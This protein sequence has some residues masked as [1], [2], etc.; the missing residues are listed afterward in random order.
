MP[1]ALVTKEEIGTIISMGEEEGVV[2]ED[3]ATM[4]RKVVK[5]GERQVREVMTPRT[6]VAWIEKEATLADFFETYAEAP[7]LRYPVYEGTFD[8]VIGFISVRD[9]VLA[10]A[11]GIL[12]RKSPLEE[13]YRP[14]YSV[15]GN[16]LVGELFAEMRS[17]GYLMAVVIDEYGGTSGIVNSEQLVEKIVG[18]IGEELVGA[19]AEFE[20]VGELAL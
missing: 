8:N 6:D 1:R 14:V 13:L 10:Q 4:L 9:V 5:F 2:D 7:A 3:E 18:E 12:D 17:T 19:T 20:V 15:P 16:K 11:Q